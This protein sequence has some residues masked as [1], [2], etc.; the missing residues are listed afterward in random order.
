[1]GSL[2]PRRRRWEGPPIPTTELLR[3][4]RKLRTAPEKELVELAE[5][6]AREPGELTKL[7]TGSV[8]AFG[9]YDNSEP[10]H[11]RRAD[12]EPLKTE[13]KMRRGHEVARALA[14]S[15]PSGAPIPVVGIPGLGLHFVDYELE[16]TRTTGAAKFDDDVK[17]TGGMTLDLLMRDQEGVPAVCE[18]K[19][20]GDRDPFFALVQ[21]LACTAHLATPAQM[22]RLGAHVPGL[23]LSAGRF[24]VFV[25]QVTPDVARKAQYQARLR[26]AAIEIASRLTDD[27]DFGGH[28][29]HV[30]LLDASRTP[31]GLRL[32]KAIPSSPGG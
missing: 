9:S 2:S 17:A 12:L 31:S 14:P 15:R 6:L 20:P 16:P 1:M 8:E 21:A 22:S 23:D 27:A 3:L 29:R 30:A 18:V 13:E 28:V 32:T 10:F 7:F 24:D 19:T 11:P 26:A 5:R 4:Y 25:I